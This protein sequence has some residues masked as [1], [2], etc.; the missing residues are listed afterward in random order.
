MWKKIYSSLL[1]IPIV[2]KFTIVSEN[3]DFQP[4]L[5]FSIYKSDCVTSSISITGIISLE[6]DINQ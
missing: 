3:C 4:Y 5:N 1:V 2:Y 6:M